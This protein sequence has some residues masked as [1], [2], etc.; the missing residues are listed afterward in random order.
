MFGAGTNNRANAEATKFV[1]WQCSFEVGFVDDEDNG[2]FTA[3]G[4]FSDGAV[5]V[6]GVLCTV[7]GD[8][9]NISKLGRF[10]DLLLN[11][12]FK[13][14]F[15]SFEPS[16]IDKPEGLACASC[17]ARSSFGRLGEVRLSS[18]FPLPSSLW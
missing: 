10:S 16:G 7:N 11:T 18:L 15:G 6:T 4:F 1:A 9:D 8:D 13:F 17:C 5:L 2:L 14:V 3:E 12:G